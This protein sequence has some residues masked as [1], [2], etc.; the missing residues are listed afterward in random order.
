MHPH[1]SCRTA[2]N[3][4]GHVADLC[5]VP[6]DREI[7]TQR[8]VRAAR[9][10][11]AMHLADHRFHRPE[12]R[13]ESLR[14]SPHA[15]EILHRVPGHVLHHL[16]GTIALGVMGKIVARAKAFPAPD[17]TITCMSRS[18]SA[19]ATAAASSQGRSSSMA[20]IT[21]GRFRVIRPIRPSF[22]NRTFSILTPNR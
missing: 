10:G 17:K 6:H 7:G 2:P 3:A 11:E 21:S 14:V 4:G 18:W 9:N 22:S 19:C 13:H 12:E 5:R 15:L 8:D 20:F 16:V 1:C